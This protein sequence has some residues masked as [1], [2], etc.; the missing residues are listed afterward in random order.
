MNK[1]KV[2]S[3][4][5]KVLVLFLVFFA[6]IVA[7]AGEKEKVLLLRVTAYGDKVKA[8]F[9]D[10][11]ERNVYRKCFIDVKKRNFTFIGIPTMF[12][13]MKDGRRKAVIESY[14]HEVLFP[15]KAKRVRRNIFLSTVYHGR[16]VLYN[17][18]DYV[19]PRVYETEVFREKILSPLNVKNY[20]YYSYKLTEINDSLTLLTF[21][22]KR[23]HT[24]LIRHGWAKVVTSTGRI[25]SFSLEGES[26]MNHFTIKGAMG[27]DGYGV[28]FPRECKVDASIKCVGNH[29]KAV[30]DTYYDMPE[31]LSD[32][33]DSSQD[34]MLMARLRPIGLSHDEE[35]LI[36]TY[37]PREQDKSKDTV[38]VSAKKNWLKTI[39][40]DIIGDNILNDIYT[41]IDNDKGY[42]RI[43]PILN[44]LYF[45]YSRKKG[46]SYKVDIRAGY[47]FNSNSD[48]YGRLRMGYSFKQKQLFYNFPITYTFNDDRNGYVKVEFSNGNRITDSRVLDSI[49]ESVH[50]D[51]IDWEGMNLDYFRDASLSLTAAY[52]VLYKRLSLKGGI[53]MHNRSAIDNSGFIIVG[54]PKVYRS[55]APFISVLW[56]PFTRKAPFAVAAQYE[57]GVKMFGGNVLYSRLEADMQYIYGLPCMRAWSFRIG[58]G[59]YFSRKGATYFLDYY[60]FRENYIPQGWHDEWSGGFELLNSNW[61]NAS[62][63]YVRG[64][65]TYESP[66]LVLSWLPF[67]GRVIEKERVYMSILGVKY[68]FPYAEVGYSFTN[69]LFSMA[70]F[71]GF[72]RRRYEGIGIKFGFELFKGW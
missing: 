38:R 32:S 10:S 13:M 12:Y 49:K 47:A 64:N 37:Y 35:E 54:R 25:V 7:K 36:K 17:L 40:W 43:A 72:S 61:Y 44:P 48:I 57:H 66:L 3:V 16:M 41:P 30:I 68:L 45:S 15:D 24:E 55:I 1:V 34:V 67:V 63:F 5:E 58:A 18:L 26:D 42:M 31:T 62:P 22:S 39:F 6:V 29:I 53:S 14:A 2:T 71:T 59:G 69:R 8:S 33:I 4:K 9:P 50:N 27:S 51:T 20:R 28:I 46:V 23:I 11:L 65:V 52:D 19:S 70:V 56:Y 60:N 21:K